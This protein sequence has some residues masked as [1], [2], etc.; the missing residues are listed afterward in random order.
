MHPTRLIFLLGLISFV[1]HTVVQYALARAASFDFLQE[2]RHWV[3]IS[4]MLVFLVGCYFILRRWNGS[5][6]PPFIK[7]WT[8]MFFVQVLTIVFLSVINLPSVFLSSSSGILP[9]P[10]AIGIQFDLADFILKTLIFAVIMPLIILVPLFLL[11][12]RKK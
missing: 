1:L 6:R 12:K 5:V 9:D 10:S 4:T 11:D 3:I 7:S 2:S 8:I